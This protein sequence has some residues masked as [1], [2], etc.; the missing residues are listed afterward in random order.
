MGG[1]NAVEML[2]IQAQMMAMSPPCQ[3]AGVQQ[4]ILLSL[5]P[6]GMQK[7][8]AGSKCWGHCLFMAILPK[9]V[10][11]GLHF[12]LVESDGGSATRLSVPVGGT[13]KIP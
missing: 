4:S 6:P 9:V 10:T 2:Q 3:M 5:P 7:Q 8:L 11:S 13:C 1:H 12:W